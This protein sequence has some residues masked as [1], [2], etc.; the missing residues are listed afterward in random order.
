MAHHAY[1]ALFN[2]YH[3]KLAGAYIVSPD[4]LGYGAA[5]AAKC[6]YSIC[7]WLHGGQNTDITCN[8]GR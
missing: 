3:N 2:A 8:A 7:T 4:Q 6:L 1:R 5:F